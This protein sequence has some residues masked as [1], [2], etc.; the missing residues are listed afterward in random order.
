MM[1]NLGL[2]RAFEREQI[3][4]SPVDHQRNLKIVEALFE[5]ARLLG[6]WP[7]SDPLEGIDVDI[8][9][10]KALNAHR[11]PDTCASAKTD[12]PASRS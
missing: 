8:R 5:E 4:H 2:V 6:V 1:R 3:R 9:L 12:P 7:P 10:A 11:A